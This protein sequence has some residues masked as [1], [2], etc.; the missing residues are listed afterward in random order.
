MK[1]KG[2]K[3]VHKPQFER[4]IDQYFYELDHTFTQGHRGLYAVLLI[5]AF[6]GVM[7]LV[8]MIPFPRLD[9]LVRMNAHTFLNWGSFYI[10][11]IVYCYLKL[12]PTLS[13]VI[14]ISIAVMSFFIVQLEYV[15]RDGGP[16][17]VLICTLITAVSLIGLWLL[18]K[19]EKNVHGKDF[20]KLLTI[21][22]IWFWSKV[23]Q[24]LRWKY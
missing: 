15:E 7:G 13:Y 2:Q 10:A 5:L 14:L 18:S 8:W 12:A 17:V 4:P 20:I 22:P 19:T 24:K 23:F 1:K 9:F 21:G 16:S 6:F 3:S 11:I